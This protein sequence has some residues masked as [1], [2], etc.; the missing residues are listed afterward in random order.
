MSVGLASPA[1]GETFRLNE[2]LAMKIR[3]YWGSLGYDVTVR[4]NPGIR[5]DMIN[6]LPR[7]WQGSGQVPC[8]SE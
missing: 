1:E 2:L 8:F 7:D 4:A 3:N 6:G 5:S